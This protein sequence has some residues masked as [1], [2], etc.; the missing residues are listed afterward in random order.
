VV[1]VGG[2]RRKRM[3]GPLGHIA[4]VT[5]LSKL[6]ARTASFF[7]AKPNSEDLATLRELLEAGDVR[8]VV[9][10]RYDFAQIADAMRVMGEGHARGK[11][12][13]TL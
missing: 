10:Q 3:L 9:E 11:L 12:V 2:P 8:P 7:I 6:G 5:L 13:V 1:L 4:R